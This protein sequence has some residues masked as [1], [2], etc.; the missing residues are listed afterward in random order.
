MSKKEK[1]I[2][3]FLSIP[4]DFTFDELVTLL[5]FFDY[6]IDTKGRSSGSRFEFINPDHRS[7]DIH[8]PHPSNV[9][10]AYQLR[11]VL[12]ILESEGLI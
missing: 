4:K 7:I 10:K 2:K 8:K 3:R 9:L 12:D 5:A 1:L 11:Q 6:Q